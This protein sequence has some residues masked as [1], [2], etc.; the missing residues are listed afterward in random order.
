MLLRNVVI[1]GL[2]S[3]YVE[4]IICYLNVDVVVDVFVWVYVLVVYFDVECMWFFVVFGGIDWIV[5]DLVE[6]WGEVDGVVVMF[7][8]GV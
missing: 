2:E 1:V 3:S 8:D 4:E 7:R 6:L 5:D